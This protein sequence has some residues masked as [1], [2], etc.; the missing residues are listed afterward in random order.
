MPKAQQV[1]LESRIIEY[2]FKAMEHESLEARQM[3]PRLLQLPD[4]ANNDELA[5]KFDEGIARVPEWV[6]LAWIPQ[7]L[8][9]LSFD[10]DSYLD[11]LI[12]RLVDTYPNALI[13]PLRLSLG[14]NRSAVIRPFLR[15]ILQRLETPLLQTFINNLHLLVLPANKLA[16]HLDR[17][18]KTLKKTGVA[19]F[20]TNVQMALDLVFGQERNKGSEYGSIRQFKKQLERIQRTE[21]K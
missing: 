19:G 12:N 14:V 10:A 4:L 13:F 1:I 16:G 15:D 8:S 21:G 20:K 9:R 17:L 11:K 18:M 2:T 3:F 6:F 7:I 5:Q